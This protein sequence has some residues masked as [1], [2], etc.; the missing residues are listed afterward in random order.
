[1]SSLLRYYT[2]KPKVTRFPTSESQ[3][4]A[5]SGRRAP[6]RK[7]SVHWTDAS[8]ESS[9]LH[10]EPQQYESSVHIER[11]R[12]AQDTD[13]YIPSND[14]DEDGTELEP[15]ARVWKTYVKESG[16]FDLD[17]V[18][19]W[20][21]SLDVILIFAALFSA[22]STASKNLRQ[23][24]ADSTAQTL[25]GISQILL[26]IAQ[27]NQSLLPQTTIEGGLSNHEEFTPSLAAICINVLWF[28][29]LILSMA[30]SLIAMLAKEWCYLFVSGRTGQPYLQARKRQQRWEGMVMWKMPELL[31]FLPS[32]M[33]W[34]LFLFAIGLSIYL[35][36]MH[37]GVALPVVLVTL[38]IL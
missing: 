31:M 18:E 34:S 15:N 26:S 28:L 22:I 4:T 5:S 9:V 1:M 25:E 11:T 14:F 35:W 7:T 6:P 8:N 29:S 20:N 33:H 24:P 17:L 23:D 2:E 37:F 38:G 27:A 12:F 10:D 30:A 13:N 3:S 21:R 19:G 32:L 36:E 16:E